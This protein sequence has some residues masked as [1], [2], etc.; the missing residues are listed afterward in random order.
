M[1]SLPRTK[2][3]PTAA[4]PLM[5]SEG[6]T[7]STGGA[8]GDRRGT[9]ACAAGAISTNVFHARQGA[10]DRRSQW[11]DQTPTALILVCLFRYGLRRTQRIIASE[12]ARFA[13]GPTHRFAA[14]PGP[15]RVRRIRLKPI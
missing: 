2:P 14:R 10:A 4:L 15:S 12:Y 11:T 7:I 3:K 9:C 5:R 8:A 1:A 13:S 6:S